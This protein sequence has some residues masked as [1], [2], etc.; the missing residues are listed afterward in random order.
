V[1]TVARSVV[2]ELAAIER[3]SAAPEA[4]PFGPDMAALPVSALW[5]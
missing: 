3:P 2:G 4:T 1:T 5:S